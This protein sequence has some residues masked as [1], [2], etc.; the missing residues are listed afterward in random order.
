MYGFRQ[1]FGDVRAAVQTAA[2]ANPDCNPPVGVDCT[3]FWEYMIH[4]NCGCTY[5][6]WMTSTFG[7][8]TAYQGLPNP[9]APTGPPAPVS[10]SANST[11]LTTPPADQ[12]TAQGTVDA[13]IAAGTAAN[14]AQAQGFFADL[15][16]WID[17]A[18]AGSTC[19]QNLISGVCDWMT[20]AGAGIVFVGVMALFGSSGRRRRR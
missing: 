10:T 2:P 9:P 6:N 8:S 7:T 1:G 13:T 12:S 11:P 19:S 17:T 14:Q 15:S 3:S 18:N 4:P 16:T 5:P 20:V